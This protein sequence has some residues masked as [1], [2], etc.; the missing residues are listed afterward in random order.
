M[1]YMFCTSACYGCGRVFTYNPDL[2]PSIRI[3]SKGQP[4]PSGQREP[5]CED[6]VE[7][8]NPIRIKNGL[9]PIRIVPGAYEAQEVL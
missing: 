6:C 1:G 2:V 3:N 4:D 5:I 7:R 9:E 8:A